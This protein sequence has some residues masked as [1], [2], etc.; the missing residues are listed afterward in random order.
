[1]QPSDPAGAKPPYDS[2]AIALDVHRA[3]S[4]R[5]DNF[6]LGGAMSFTADRELG[7]KIVAAF[8]DMPLAAWENQML[9][10]RA[11]RY[12]AGRGLRQFL[13]IGTAIP[14]GPTLHEIV[15]AF[16]PESRVV[17]LDHDPIVLATV[18]ALTTS[19]PRGK[20]TC[21]CGDLAEPEQI[22]KALAE[23]A[24]L[25]LNR[26]IALAVTAVLHC[27]S[28]ASRPEQVL[29]TLRARLAPDSALIL[30][31]AASDLNQTSMTQVADACREAG[32][33]F[34]PRTRE[35]VEAFFD[36][37]DLVEPGITT[38]ARWHPV[39]PPGTSEAAAYYAGVAVGIGTDPRDAVPGATS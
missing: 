26:P 5:V 23:D 4:A 2:F 28:D 13:D 14:L 25:D 20:V 36:G 11:A 1:M 31:H 27:L 39:C 16:A 15:Q 22:L 35:Q 9:I 3:Q 24:T 7:R 17:Y 34:H 18:E 33:P 32:M 38:P 12:L 29:K 37:W 8:P 30:T 19:D 6:L 21:L 10:A